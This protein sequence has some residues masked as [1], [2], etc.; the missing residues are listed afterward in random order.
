MVTNVS[1]Y[2]M[3]QFLKKH[4]M[5]VWITA[6]VPLAAIIPIFPLNILF[7]TIQLTALGT[8][9]WIGFDGIFD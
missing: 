1:S 6:F 9:F 4:K 7:L 8:M 3:K 2:P 5:A